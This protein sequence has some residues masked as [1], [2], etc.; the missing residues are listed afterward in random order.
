MSYPVL[1][2][3]LLSQFLEMENLG[4]LSENSVHTL[5]QLIQKY[6]LRLSIGLMSHE[7]S[8][9]LTNKGDSKKL[10]KV[11]NNHVYIRSMRYSKPWLSK[12]RVNI[13]V[14]YVPSSLND[15]TK[16]LF[17]FKW[18]DFPSFDQ[19]NQRMTK[20]KQFGAFSITRFPSDI[21]IS[22][23]D[24]Q[25]YKKQLEGL[26][27]QKLLEPKKQR[28]T[29]QE[30]RIEKLSEYLMALGLN[31][32]D[33]PF[34]KE[35][36]GFESRVNCWETLHDDYPGVFGI[37]GIKTIDAFFDNQNLIKFKENKGVLKQ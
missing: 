34:S 15:S 30:L 3:Y 18:V 26:K 31:L 37:V 22:S 7:N 16:M 23:I 33:A 4:E 10:L 36:H 17:P 8:F 11:Q 2:Q 6:D 19:E 21:F 24:Y 20:T 5:N 9:C 28:L 27:D 35:G 32:S 13:N 25:K 1:D 14:L 12:P 29:K